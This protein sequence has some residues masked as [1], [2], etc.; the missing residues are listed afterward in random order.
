MSQPDILE[1]QDALNVF[2][3]GQRLIILDHLLYDAGDIISID[4][5]FCLIG[6]WCKI[7]LMIINWNCQ[8]AAVRGEVKHLLFPL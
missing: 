3:R 2:E 4:L 8:K 6:Y 7:I 5:D 1:R